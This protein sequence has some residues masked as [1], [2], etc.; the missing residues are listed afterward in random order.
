VI[1][2]SDENR[3]LQMY[4]LALSLVET[5]GVLVTL[6]V[7]TFKEYRAG[8]LII[9]HL[10][11]LGRLDIWY[12]RKVLAID[13]RAGDLRVIVFTPGEDWEKELEK[14]G[15]AKSASKR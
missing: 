11:S 15:A 9:H 10:P 1:S 6:G 3:A 5:K 14:A 4:K 2:P 13:K 12:R 7:T 8:N